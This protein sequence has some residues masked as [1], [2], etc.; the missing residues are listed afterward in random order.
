MK[1]LTAQT[2]E[3]LDYIYSIVNGEKVFAFKAV[4]VTVS[5]PE[6][7]FRTYTIR[8]SERSSILHYIQ[9]DTYSQI[10]G[11]QMKYNNF[12]RTNTYETIA[13]FESAVSRISKMN[14]I[15]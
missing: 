2:K 6:N 11:R 13:Q 14:I 3:K 15:N 7:R 9:C 4:I 8:R 12:T 1:N 5:L 10:E